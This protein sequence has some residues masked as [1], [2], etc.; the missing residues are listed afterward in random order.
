M[1][2]VHWQKEMFDEE[3]YLI[4]LK[5]E[6]FWVIDIIIVKLDAELQRI[7]IAELDIKNINRPL[8]ALRINQLK[9]DILDAR[10]KIDSMRIQF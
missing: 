6:I 1:E 5:R 9:E 10:S 4:D 8:E 3:Y 7:S 2:E